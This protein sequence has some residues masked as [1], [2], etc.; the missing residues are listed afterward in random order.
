MQKYY[1]LDRHIVFAGII[2]HAPKMTCAALECP[3]SCR[4][5]HHRRSCTHLEIADT[6][7]IQKCPQEI[8]SAYYSYTS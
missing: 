6:L 5:N 7:I 8:N 2:R 1:Q 3:S 4:T